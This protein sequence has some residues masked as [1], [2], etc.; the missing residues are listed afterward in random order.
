MSKFDNQ[1][2]AINK[3]LINLAKT[4][5]I[6]HPAYQ[7]Y[8]NK[9]KLEHIPT[10]TNSQG[11][12][13]VKRTSNPNDYQR[14]RVDKLYKQ[15][16][17]VTSI[18]KKYRKKHPEAKIREAIDKAIK[19]RMERQETVNKTLDMIYKYFDVGLLPVDIVEKYNNLRQHDTSNDEIDELVEDMAEFDALVPHIYEVN[20]LVQS[21]DYVDEDIV[22]DMWEIMSGRLS[23]EEV[24]ETLQEV[25]D[26][27][28]RGE[29]DEEDE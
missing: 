2:N 19:A 12:V 13:Q 5:G 8:A 6:N 14:A 18:R 9:L 23:L 1:A 22:Q 26:Y 27:L 3:R 20:D 7:N 15:G 28:A 29:E 25:E 11:V 24:K 10:R 16:D 4:Y 21:L 17:T